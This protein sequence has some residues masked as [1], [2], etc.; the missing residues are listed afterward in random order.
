MSL[1]QQYHTGR[2]AQLYL[3]TWQVCPSELVPTSNTNHA[4]EMNFLL[5]SQPFSLLFLLIATGVHSC[6]C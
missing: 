4:M 1:D 3:T 5:S 2:V 6:V